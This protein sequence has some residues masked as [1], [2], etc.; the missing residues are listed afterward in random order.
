MTK[1]KSVVH[2]N[3]QWYQINFKLV[4]NKKHNLKCTSKPNY[5]IHKIFDNNLVAI[6]KSKVPIKL[7]KP[8]YIGMC[9]F[10]IE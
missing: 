3:E 5:M 4:S 6:Q 10:G 7:N 1:W 2:F 9:F 8:D